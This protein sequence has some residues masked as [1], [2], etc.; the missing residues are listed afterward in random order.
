VSPG[1]A[2]L[3]VEEP[4]TVEEPSVDPGAVEWLVHATVAHASTEARMKLVDA[5]R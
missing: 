3:D 2:P 1:P 4:V 5:G